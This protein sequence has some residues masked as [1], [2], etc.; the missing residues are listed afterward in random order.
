MFQEFE[1]K[2]E[3]GIE[4]RTMWLHPGEDGETV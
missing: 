1:A 4:K 2:G 3:C